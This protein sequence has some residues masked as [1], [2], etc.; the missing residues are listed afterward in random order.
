MGPNVIIGKDFWR[1][2]ET[3]VSF[4]SCTVHRPLVSGERGSHRTGQNRETIGLGRDLKLVLG[5][6]QCVFS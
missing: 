5:L 2:R 6:K 1:L 3:G 4:L